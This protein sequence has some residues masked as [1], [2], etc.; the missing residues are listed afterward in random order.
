MAARIDG[1]EAW[2]AVCE[3]RDAPCFYCVSTTGIYCRTTCPSRRPRREH[4]RFVASAA[5]A[6]RAGFRA[7][8]RCRPDAA[9]APELGVATRACEAIDAALAAG[10]SISLDRLGRSVGLSGGR[11][12]RVFKRSLGVSPRAWAA[13]R[14]LERFRESLR[15]HD[16][17]S[18][19]VLAAGYASES[20]AYEGVQSRLGMTPSAYRDLGAGAV[21][22][23]TVVSCALGR[24]LVAATARGL[25]SVRFG[26][27]GAALERELRAEFSK[28]ELVGADEELAD[29][30][31]AVV[32]A[33][34]GRAPRV[35][36]P[37]DVR[38]TAFQRQVWQALRAIPIGETRSYR[39]V[40][41]AIGRPTAA[42]AVASACAA[43]PVAVVVPCHRVVREDRS[44]GGYRWGVRRKQRLLDAERAANSRGEHDEVVDRGTRDR[45]RPGDSERR[46]GRKR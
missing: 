7:C 40:A 41:A 13:E 36:L 14:R 11:L 35:D 45:V 8:R 25:C 27:D 6:V 4:V 16:R 34:E 21:I 9:Q 3:R 44:L 46:G 2:R 20:R 22:R 15:D 29:W 17:V 5:D 39:Q 30:A 28:A 37:L 26:V 12:Q 38:A 23:F 19:A 24:V 33:I 1:E 43:N 10:E 32:R 42:R 31:G 18:D